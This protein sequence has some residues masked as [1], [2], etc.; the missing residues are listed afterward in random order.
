LHGGWVRG[1][2]FVEC[3]DSL[4][5]V[6]FLSNQFPDG[7]DPIDHMLS[8]IADNAFFHPDDEEA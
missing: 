1:G 8:R 3:A 4:R 2:D 6:L 7:A 5:Y